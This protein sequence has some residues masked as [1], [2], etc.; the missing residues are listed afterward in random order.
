MIYV[1]FEFLIKKILACK[2]KIETLSTAN[3]GEHIA[4]AYSISAV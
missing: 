1:D 4:C 3:A 2:D